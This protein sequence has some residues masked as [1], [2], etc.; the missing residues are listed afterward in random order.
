MNLADLREIDLTGAIDT[1]VRLNTDLAP[2]ADAQLISGANHV[3]GGNRCE[4]HGCKGRRDA[5]KKIGA[6][7]REN[8]TRG[9]SHKFLKLGEGFGRQRGGWR[10]RLAG[11]LL[12]V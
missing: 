3:V 2:N 6:I 11:Q 9:R 4:L 1:Q 7:N 12:D 8:E 10:S 5:A